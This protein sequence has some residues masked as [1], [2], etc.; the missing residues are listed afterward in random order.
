MQPNL[1]FGR[2]FLFKWKRG[3]IYVY[4]T[5][6]DSC[7]RIGVVPFEWN[8][9]SFREEFKWNGSSRWN[10]F[11]KQVLP[12]DVFSFS[13]FYWNFRKFL[14]HLSTLTSDRLQSQALDGNNSERM[15]E[16]AADLQRVNRCNVCGH[17]KTQLQPRR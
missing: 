3:V 8:F 4:H 10:V 2:S 9:L 12:F 15:L 13:R 6:F 16:M 17:F 1:E 7:P 11:G 14:Y 5:L